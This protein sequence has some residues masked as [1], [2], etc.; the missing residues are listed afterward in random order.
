MFFSLKPIESIITYASTSALCIP[1]ENATLG[2]PDVL[3]FAKESVFCGIFDRCNFALFWA[4]MS[5]NSE[6]AHIK[7]PSMSNTGQ[8]LSEE[9]SDICAR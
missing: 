4:E 3:I 8:N 5:G 9:W 6:I 7:A 1:T 2:F